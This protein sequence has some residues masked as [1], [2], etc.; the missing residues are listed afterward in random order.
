MMLNLVCEIRTKASASLLR[1]ISLP[2]IQA[3][4]IGMFVDRHKLQDEL[5]KATK[6]DWID[7]CLTLDEKYYKQENCC[8]MHEDW[9][10][11]ESLAKKNNWQDLF[12]EDEKGGNNEW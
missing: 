2:G 10:E 4:L 3:R 12:I 5:L 8:K 11:F 7:R 6:Q 1:N 9:Q